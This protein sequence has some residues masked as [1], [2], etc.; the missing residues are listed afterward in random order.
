MFGKKRLCQW[1]VLSAALVVLAGCASEG[2][3]GR[4]LFQAA[5]FATTAPRAADFVESSRTDAG[6][7]PVGTAAPAR[8]KPKSADDIK[9]MEAELERRRASNESAAADA[10]RSAK[11]K[12][13]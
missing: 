3:T 2:D 4:G 5:G 1:G 6:Y 9:A 10:L 13:N 7:I 11:P 12:T 8:A